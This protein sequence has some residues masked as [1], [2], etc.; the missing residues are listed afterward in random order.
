MRTGLHAIA[1]GIP[2]VTLVVVAAALAVLLSYSLV[3]FAIVAV[4]GV[5]AIG[6]Q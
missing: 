4:Q 5:S 3:V 1:W 2:A 6:G